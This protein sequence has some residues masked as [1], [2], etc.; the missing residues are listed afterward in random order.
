MM[1]VLRV[2]GSGEEVWI[3]AAVVS[4]EAPAGEV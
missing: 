2:R 1:L 4:N 3:V